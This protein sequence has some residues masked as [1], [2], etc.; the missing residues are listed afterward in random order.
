MYL[1]LILCEYRIYNY[2]YELDDM[3]KNVNVV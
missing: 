1:E 3:K 2:L